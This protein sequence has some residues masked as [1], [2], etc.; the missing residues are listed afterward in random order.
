MDFKNRLFR[1]LVI[2]KVTGV[3]VLSA[4]TITTY[5]QVINTL[6]YLPL[7]F[8]LA[9]SPTTTPTPTRTNTPTPTKTSTPTQT[10]TRTPTRTTTS[11]PTK[12]NTPT[13]TSI[14]V[15]N[16]GNIAIIT[17]NRYGSGSQEPDEYVEIKNLDTK[18][19]QVQGWTLRDIANHIYTFPA[20]IME[21]NMICRVYTNQYQPT[22]CGFSYGSNAA[23]WNNT[24]DCGYLRNSAGIEKS[25]YCY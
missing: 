14:P 18:R 23:I 19:I 22:Y 21:P 3:L 24:N 20:F 15:V 10:P 8:N 13:Q 5:A 7:V 25:T 16:D 17:I 2:I 12:T 11:T 6:T 4:L 1:K 9:P